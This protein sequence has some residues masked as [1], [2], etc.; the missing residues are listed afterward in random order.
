M[1]VNTVLSATGTTTA[2]A[3]PRTCDPPT[4]AMVATLLGQP[5]RAAGPSHRRRSPPAAIDR[6]NGRL[7]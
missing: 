2:A 7:S 6:L 4:C 3:L 1:H 5:P